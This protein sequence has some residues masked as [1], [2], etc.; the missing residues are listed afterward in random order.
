MPV[1]RHATRQDLTEEDHAR[2]LALAAAGLAVGALAG[3]VGTAFHLALDG[4]ERFR[5]SML[6]WAHGSPAIGWLA[7]VLLAAAAAFIARWLVRR[8]APEASGSGVQRVEE[9][10]RGD[11][12]PMRAAVLPV[13]FIGGVLALGT[14]MALGREGPTVQMGATIGH[15]CW[16][17]FKLR[18]GDAR[19]LLAAG[20]GAGLAAA[21]NAPLAGAIFVFEEL[22]RRFELR[23]AVATFAACSGALA[24]MRSLIGDHLVFSVPTIEV[25]L[26][27]GYL[28]FLVLGGVMGAL[29]VAYNR[30][31][32]AG[33]DLADRVRRVPP[34]IP[35]AIIG[36]VVGL[37]A[38]LWPDV[39]GGGE[40]QVQGV[41][42]GGHSFGA[43]GFL[44]A[45][46][47]VLGPLCYAPGFPGGLFAPLLIVGAAAGMLFGMAVG[48]LVPA[49]TTPLSAFAAVGMGALFVG[50]VRAPTTGVALVVE[51]T[52]ATSL[53]VPLLTACASAVAVPSMLGSPPIYDTLQARDAAQRRTSAAA[54][55]ASDFA[56]R[57]GTEK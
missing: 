3:L 48:M 21:F 28:M 34:E 9:I 27:P 5:A 49:M 23:V 52:G 17:V 15:L 51:M 6:G 32:V 20:A 25:E 13:K 7:P 10:I 54:Q 38:W 31:I 57:R 18:A 55:N 44:F 39:V 19:V 4:A 12:V 50:V 29:G 40:S 1:D 35:A 11:V 14:G 56:R 26:F 24:V 42:D 37:L 30:M 8:Y 45:V 2:L 46:R 53:F 22:L 47:L 36:G 41:L 33:L 16:R 43:L